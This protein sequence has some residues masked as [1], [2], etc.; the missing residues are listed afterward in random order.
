MRPAILK[1]PDEAIFRSMSAIHTEPAEWLMASKLGLGLGLQITSLDE[2]LR[3]TI[4]RLLAQGGPLRASM[5]QK[6]VIGYKLA[7]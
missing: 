4:N 2:L 5:E 1:F 3:R 6:C 7:E